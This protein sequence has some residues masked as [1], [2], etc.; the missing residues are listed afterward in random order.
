MANGTELAKAYVQIIPSAKGIKGTLEQELGSAGSTSGQ[1]F[2]SAFGGKLKTGLATAAKAG[3]AAL[4]AAVA[5][6]AALGTQ[7]IKLYSDYEQLVGGVETLFG[8]GGAELEEYAAS[9][10][11]TV[12]DAEAEYNALIAAQ[13]A[14]MAN[15][16]DA[17]K[18]AGMSANEYMD[19]V[20][21][22]S[23]ALIQGLGGD[24]QAA[25]EVANVAITDMADNA[26]K[27]GTDL[28]SIQYAY[29]GFAKQNYTM[30]DNLKLGYGG[31]QAE[32]ARLI[33]D[34]GVLGDTMEVTAET[35]NQV[36]FDKIVEA[37]HVVQDEMG[38][39]GTTADEAATT[40][41]GSI[42]SMKAAWDNFLAGMADPEQDFDALLG[43]LVDSVV[44]VGKN[45]VP[46]IQMLL[47]RLAEGL[48]QLANSLLP[49]IP[50]TLQSL[51]PTL[52]DGASSLISGFT[53][54]L[55]D[56]ITTAISAI[57][58]LAGAAVSII[59]NLVTALGTA[60]PQL[61]SAGVQLLNQL[62]AGI[63]TGLPTL[64]E[65]IPAMLQAGLGY[66][67]QQLPTVIT[68]G[69]DLL[70]ALMNGI[71]SAIPVMAEQLPVIVQTVL[72]GITVQLPSVLNKGVELLTNLVNGILSAIPS[73]LEQLPQI[74]DNFI[75]F[76]TSNLP[77]IL[78]AGINLLL[79]LTQGI[80]GAIPQLV[81][82]LPKII[83]SITS[84]LANNLP[85]II[86]SG[87][88]M[89]QKL[90]E[91]IIKTIPQL[92]A[93]LPQIITAIVN[94]IGALM[95][96]ILDI[97]VNIVKGIWQGIQSM[98]SWF[99]NQVKNFFS[100]I[101]NGVKKVL[102]IK[103][104]SRVFAS[105]GGY[106]AEGLGEGWSDEYSGVSRGL[107]SSVQD[108]SDAV[109][110]QFSGSL[111]A[112]ALEADLSIHRAG[113][114]E[115]ALLSELRALGDRIERMRI[116]LDSGRLVGGIAKDMDAAMGKIDARA[117]RTS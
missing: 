51:L 34:S 96:G 68:A 58:Q 5:G 65:R 57:P 72:D 67:T 18:N 47:P 93:S 1:A 80:I 17:W 71:L 42:S 52:I 98:V 109:A 26:N 10:G 111:S 50:T 45:L 3:L 110:D 79:N 100:G 74:I 22:F 92:V 75:S 99:T 28:A 21:A 117:V 27:M 62:V 48:T 2:N 115:S 6:I 64:A 69:M 49:Y 86:Q 105:I 23:A 60:A 36:S 35:V 95:G 88:Q 19:T 85:Q 61:L 43:N 44:T 107:L 83:T 40:I 31:T 55:P 84:G 76:I 114:G 41:Q 56:I 66:L 106:M 70:N 90:I 32:M 81:A 101:V 89:L 7:S 8:A 53:A 12:S 116:Y 104:P 73:M 102:G 39:T 15:A 20:T 112:K 108:T 77:T 14:V 87:V 9:V 16:R 33:N 38:I 113:N 59:G 29:Q 94:G 82:Q 25:A 54:V 13:D 4:G 103:S 11:K 46:R 97:G 91:G 63:E 37:I 30:L 24:T 78:E